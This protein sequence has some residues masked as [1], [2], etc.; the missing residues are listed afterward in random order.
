[1]YFRDPNKE[2]PRVYESVLIKFK[3]GRYGVAYYSGSTKRWYLEF[4][5]DIPYDSKN[6]IG[7]MPLSELDSVEI[8]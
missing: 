3:S 6:I 2:L 4:H 7:W 5:D 8:K 1:M